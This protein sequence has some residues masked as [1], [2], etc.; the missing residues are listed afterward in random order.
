MNKSNRNLLV[1]ILKSIGTIGVIIAHLLPPFWLFNLRTFDVVALVFASGLTLKWHGETF[2]EYCSYVIK[3][4]RRLILPTWFFIAIYVLIVQVGVSLDAISPSYLLSKEKIFLTYTLTG[5]VGYFW[6]IRVYF[7][8]ALVSPIIVYISK[9]QHFLK[10]WPVF[11]LIMVGLNELFAIY[12]D[13]INNEL[14]R[15]LFK[16]IVVYTCGYAIVEIIAKLSGKKN[17]AVLII[18][19]LLVFII[20]WV[21]ND[22]C[23]PDKLKYPPQAVYTFYGI[24]I[25]LLIALLYETSNIK[26]EFPKLSSGIS[27]VVM[28]ISSNSLWIYF[29]HIAIIPF[30]NHLNLSFSGRFVMVITL[31]CLI[32]GIQNYMNKIIKIKI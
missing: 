22:F 24:S 28:W 7:T 12:S 9:N 13:S 3:R 16:G 6:I 1:D 8:L 4:F 14:M 18:F 20:F 15:N 2:K 29:W 5:G 23:A 30:A 11:I 25:S 17:K 27:N 21:L 31:S 32:T 26:F 10:F 19:A